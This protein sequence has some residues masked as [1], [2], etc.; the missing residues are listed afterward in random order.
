M[1]RLYC[2][3]DLSSYLTRS[4][5][6][7]R[8]TIIHPKTRLLV[9]S[10]RRFPKCCIQLFV[11]GA[12][13]RVESRYSSGTATSSPC[14]LVYARRRRVAYREKDAFVCQCTRTKD[15]RVHGTFSDVLRSP[16][17]QNRGGGLRVICHRCYKSRLKRDVY[18]INTIPYVPPPR[19]HFNIAAR[20]DG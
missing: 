8:F 19:V 12:C 18:A 16:A 13:S 6:S 4:I 1:N 11:L 17:Y 7:N 20:Y 15:V 5:S 9:I 10:C 14:S 3:Q 2:I